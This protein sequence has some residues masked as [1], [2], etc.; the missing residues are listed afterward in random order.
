MLIMQKIYSS[1]VYLNIGTKKL[2]FNGQ[3]VCCDLANAYISIG[4]MIVSRPMLSTAW[5]SRGQSLSNS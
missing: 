3:F 1:P 2:T 4:V 5:N